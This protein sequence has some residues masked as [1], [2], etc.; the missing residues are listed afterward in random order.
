M[1]VV[2]RLLQLFTEQGHGAYFGEAVTE[3]EHALQT[4]HL[5]VQAGAEPTLITAALLHDIGHLLHGLGEDI[6]TQGVDGKHE[7]LGAHWLLQH[8]G[9]AVADPVRLHVPA[10]RYLCAVEPC[11]A[12]SLSAAS[13]QSLAL[14]GGPFTAEEC[15]QFEQERYWQSAVQLRRWDDTAKVPG[16]VVPGVEAYRPVLNAVLLQQE[17]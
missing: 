14:Q 15:Q 9:P 4:A 1:S 12:E 13:Q 2:N 3:T 17:N 16:L 6:A 5:A 8:F 10:K 11:Y 7:D